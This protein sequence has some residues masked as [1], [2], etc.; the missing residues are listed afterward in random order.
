[1][2]F[3]I[4]CE[5]L[6]V[7]W[8]TFELLICSHEILSSLWVPVHLLYLNFWHALMESQCPIQLVRCCVLPRL[9]LSCWHAFMKSHLESGLYLNHW[10]INFTSCIVCTC[11]LPLASLM[12]LF[13]QSC[14]VQV[15]YIQSL[16]DVQFKVK[17]YLIL[18]L[19]Y[20]QLHRCL[21]C[22]VSL[23]WLI[24]PFLLYLLFLTAI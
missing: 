23:V 2:K 10:Y 9:Y 18:L 11:L 24:L 22:L 17:P 14:I 3:H 8:A 16:V 19:I 7:F 4:G 20:S 13:W 1:M 12:L 5:L 15:G 21:L 6:C